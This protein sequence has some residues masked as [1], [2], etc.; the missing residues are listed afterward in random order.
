MLGA[1]VRN[2]LAELRR[3]E[4]ADHEHESLSLAQ[5]RA[6]SDIPADQ[7]LFHC[8]LVS[9]ASWLGMPEIAGMSNGRRVRLDSALDCPLTIQVCRHPQ[10]NVKM[11]CRAEGLAEADV[12]L[13]VAH[14]SAL[15]GQI[16][17]GGN[18]KVG[19]LSLMT[20]EERRRVLVTW[21][22]TA[23]E[24]PRAER[25]HELIER[26][27]E[28]CGERAAVICGERTLTYAELNR[29]AN[30]LAH[31]LL[32]L[33]IGPNMSVGVCLPQSP[34]MVVAV[35][36]I[37]KASGTYA[38]L[39]PSYPAHRLAGMLEDL[40]APAVVTERRFTAS[41]PPHAGTT[42]CLDHPTYPADPNADANPAVP[43]GPED[44]IYVIFTSGSTG[45][46]KGSA[47]RHRGFSNLLHWYVSEF[48]L[49]SDDRFLLMS[50]FGFDLTQ[51]NIFAPLL[52]GDSFTCRRRRSTIPSACCTRL[53]AGAS[54]C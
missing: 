13:M 49:G 26:Q 14:L 25:V 39:D 32:A 3:Q 4:A 15:L 34:E 29:R 11:L 12:K 20:D 35:L 9:D 19:Q 43:V 53:P 2:W 38:P 51:K 5:Y 23:R 16:A 48:G 40:A 17:A 52:C 50:S 41:L 30:R 8:R 18:R 22:G 31:R 47:V 1:R 37:L 7:P 10:L 36:G 45:R 24:Y 21:N 28:A 33:G 44:L 46:P 27:V 42:L 54:P 6:L